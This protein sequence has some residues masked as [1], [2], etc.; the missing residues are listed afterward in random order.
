MCFAKNRKLIISSAGW[1]NNFFHQAGFSQ[2]NQYFFGLIKLYSY[3]YISLKYITFYRDNDMAKTFSST[4]KY[5]CEIIF[6]FKRLTKK[7]QE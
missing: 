7:V 1:A 2:T 4:Q 6:S 3:I 5:V